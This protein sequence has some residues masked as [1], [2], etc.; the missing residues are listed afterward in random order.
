[1]TRFFGLVF[2]SFLIFIFPQNLKALTTSGSD[3]LTIN[4]S[5]ISFSVKIFESQIKKEVIETTEAWAKENNSDISQFSLD[6]N[7]SLDIF[8]TYWNAPGKVNNSDL[9]LLLTRDD[10]H[11]T[12]YHGSSERNGMQS[13]IVNEKSPEYNF[14]LRVEYLLEKDAFFIKKKITI[15]DTEYET[16]FLQKIHTVNSTIEDV[17]SVVKKGGYGQPAAFTIK[18]GGGFIGVEFPTATSEINNLNNKLFTVE[19]IAEKIT[20][21]GVSS[22]WTVIGITPKSNVKF[23][24]MNYLNSVRVAKL[25]PYTLYNSWYDLRSVEYPNVPSKYWMN[26]KN[27]FRIINEIKSSFVEKHGI[28]IDAFVLDDGWDIY[29]SDWKLRTKQFPHGMLPIS[30][31]LK[32]INSTLGMWFGPTGGY[33][34]RMKRINWMKAHGYEVVGTHGIWQPMLCIAGKN[35][36]K[37]FMKRVTDFVKNANVGYYKWDGIQFSCS[38]PNHGHPIGEYSRRAV[39]ESVADICDTVRKLNPDIFLNITSGTWL[40]PWWVKYANTIW[41]QGGDYGYSDVPSISSRDR[42]ITYRDITLYNDFQK[43]NLWFP[44]SN[45]MTHGIIKG[46][47]QKLGGESEPIDKFTDNAVLYFARGVAMYEL[48]ISPD[49]LSNDEWNAL[50][51][52]LKWGKDNFDILMNTEMIGGDPSKGESYGYIHV[53]ESDGIVAVR[54]PKI[55]KDTIKFI[56]S[57]DYG[58]NPNTDNLIM[59]EV[60]PRNIFSDKTY[61]CGDEI[62]VVLNGFETAIFNFYPLDKANKP[63]ISNVDFIKQSENSYL[64]APTGKKITLLSDKEKFNLNSGKKSLSI[65]D[66]IG[67]LSELHQSRNSTA[68]VVKISPNEFFI[69]PALNKNTVSGKIAI[70]FTPDKNNADEKPSLPEISVL[71]NGKK[72]KRNKETEKG[73]WE[74]SSYQIENNNK[75]KIKIDG[76]NGLS[77]EME[78]YLI[79]FEKPQGKKVTFVKKINDKINPPR[80]IPDGLIKKEI[81]VKNIKIKI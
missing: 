66:L 56:L 29:Q 5:K 79:T 28:K 52:S 77:G 61:K 69:S 53:K 31:K 38:E 27:V 20:S 54:N 34:F 23:W 15:F 51:Q 4:N 50:A 24:F 32:E 64:L 2:Y 1:M 80:P 55:A 13:I 48:Y 58:M 60:Y 7:F 33:S 10:F 16:H 35:Y 75:L 14:T 17:Q 49:I 8:W 57:S 44:I 70:L 26:E 46:E 81:L 59:E 71:S 39:M 12:D 22:S 40:S 76:K 11:V 3:I 63:V 37:L 74:W 62:T 72:V 67:K 43:N 9:Q 78:I 36:K 6:G 30:E 68:E 47:L 25:K 42:A 41:M 21:A 65:D 73:K 19:T 18:N 45:L